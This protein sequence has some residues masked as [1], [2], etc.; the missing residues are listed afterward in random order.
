[1]NDTKVELTIGAELKDAILTVGLSGIL[2]ILLIWVVT[3]VASRFGVGKG[4][5][6]P[7]KL[8]RQYA[9]W[10][11]GVAVVIGVCKYNWP[12]HVGEWWR[13]NSG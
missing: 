6:S 13:K 7:I 1:M 11:L 4:A 5:K 2:L 8:F 9:L 3:Y 12:H 10:T